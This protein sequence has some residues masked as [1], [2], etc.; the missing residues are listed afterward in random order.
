MK[1]TGSS[2]IHSLILAAAL[3]SGLGFV[4]PVS[5]EQ[6]GSYI[7]D[8]G[9]SGV[10]GLGTLGG[11]F[12]I[13]TGINDAGQAIGY[14]YIAAGDRHA[15]ITG[16]NG[17]GITDLGTLGG[18]SST[19]TGV[20]DAGQVVGDSTTATGDQHAFITGPNGVGMNDL[21]T[22]GGNSSTATGINDDGQV[23]G[24][25]TT[26][27]EDRHAFITR[28]NGVL[29]TDLNSLAHPPNGVV[30]TE[31]VGINNQ[32]RLVAI[33]VIP[34]PE[35]YAMLLAGLGLLG[36]VM[37]GNR[38]MWKPSPPK[39]KITWAPE[40][41]GDYLHS[42]SGALG[43]FQVSFFSA[44]PGFFRKFQ[45]FRNSHNVSRLIDI[46]TPPRP[47]ACYFPA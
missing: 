44:I 29:I 43:D 31:A 34:E 20:N 30:L 2:K 21:G 32:G 5:A 14:S 24:Y 47:R 11:S 37:R 13:A 9:G 42:I 1:I 23:V 38:N 10:M 26:L 46:F 7:V 36:F 4:S 17:V 22:L 27:T 45:V 33:S 12:S 18:N 8:T 3:S 6:Q 41:I 28:S 40:H 19:A 25:F 35:I 39:R 16:P 15:F